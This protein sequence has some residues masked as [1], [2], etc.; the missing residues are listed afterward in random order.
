MIFKVVIDKEKE[1]S[2]VATIHSKTELIDEIEQLVMKDMIKDQLP[3][4]R[5]DEISML[6]IKDIECFCTEDEKTYAV[7]EDSKRYLI[8]KRLYEL[9]EFLPE[10]FER[11]SKSAI[12]N[13]KKI[14]RFKVQLSGAVDAVFV[15]GYSECISRRCFADLK[16]RY[17]L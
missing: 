13:W 11:I 15:S 1:E 10:E 14:K 16:R 4:Y 7:Y 3:G 17:D 6:K 8:K 2:I 9:E 5:D 12:A